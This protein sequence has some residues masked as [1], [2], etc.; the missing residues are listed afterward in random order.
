MPVLEASTRERQRPRLA[1]TLQVVSFAVVYVVAARIGFR[2]AFVAEQVSPVWPPAGL[3]LG[4]VLYFGARVW[5]AVWLG[6]VTANLT[7]HL[8]LMAACGIAT[9]N[10]LEALVGAS[11][12]RRFGD[13]DWSLD[14][15]RHVTVLILGAAVLSTAVSATIGVTTLCLAG[16]QPWTRFGLLWWIWWLGDATGDLLVAPVLLTVPLWWIGIKRG[17][18]VAEAVAVEAAAIAVSTVV[19]AVRLTP[20]TGH[21]SLSFAVFPF[22]IW[23]ALR[24][25]HPG[26]A[27]VSA[28]VSC[29]AVWG[30]LH[31][32]GPF[33]GTSVSSPQEAIIL[34]Q[35]Y[36]AVIATTGLV[37]GAAIADRNRSERLRKADHALTAILSEDHDLKG[38]SPRILKAVCETQ[39]WDVGLLWQTDDEQR[40]LE[41]VHSWQRDRGTDEFVAASRDRRFQP[42]IGLP[43]RVWSS[44]QPA[45]IYDVV[46]DAN[47]PRS[48]VAARLGLHSGFAFP[49][50]LGQHV[51]GVMEFFTREPRKADDSLLTLMT[52]V[53]SQI[54]QFID[55]RRAQQ[56]VAESD[57]LNSA[58]V[59]AALD[60]VINI[61]ANG[62]ILEFNPA[63]ARTFGLGRDQALGRELA[64]VLVPARL[65]DRHRDALRRCVETGEARIL[66]KR[67]EMPALRADG[68][69]FPVELTVARVWIAQRPVFTAC[70]RDITDRKRGEEDSRRLNAELEER[71]RQ[72]TAQLQAAVDELEAFS[73]SVSHDL[74]APLRSIDGFSQALVEDIGPMLPI[75]ARDHLDRVRAATQRMG[76]LIDDLLTL[77]KA[78]RGEMTRERIDLSDVATRVVADLRRQGP[79]RSVTFTIGPAM[80]ALG[81]A[82]WVRVALENLLANAWKFT[83]DR[84]HACIDVGQTSRDGLDAVFYVRD[85]G[86][87]FD[88]TYT[89][90]L[91][92]PF[93]RLHAVSEFPGSGIGLATVRRIVHRHGGRVWAEG[94]PGQG[95]CFYFTLS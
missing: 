6:A 11:L 18:R 22:V 61:D 2:A 71:V 66:G 77:S 63:A 44:A 60:C 68:T 83:R 45:W 74:R 5:P 20:L 41:Y 79:D 25:A 49:I 69:E 53:G 4:A 29:I 35:I 80:T 10:T 59:N 94:Q 91:F 38:A 65:R 50:L 42:D 85:N 32:T 39:D 47:F 58:I 40:V 24:F 56:R 1:E 31:G 34:L 37:F 51:L 55:R 67:V 62:R 95:A 76:H 88:P 28:S 87:G 54:G 90:R 15:L 14:G 48:A 43:G 3:A 86:A 16:L 57:A 7:T 73:Y 23:A 84:E 46:I 9:G 72:R 64:E 17:G 30:T 36:T 21:H 81:D 52:A 92:V 82:R 26:A 70:I 33:S 19:F 78:S 89:D 75:E 13:V 27:L 12:L 8:P 93:Q